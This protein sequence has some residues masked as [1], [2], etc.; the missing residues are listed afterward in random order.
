MSFVEWMALVATVLPAII[1]AAHAYGIE[2]PF[3]SA[4]SDWIAARQTPQKPTGV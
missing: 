4:L 3:L 2:L 1:K